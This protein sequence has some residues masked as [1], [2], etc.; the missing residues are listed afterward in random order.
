VRSNLDSSRP[1]FIG[2]GS[3]NPEGE[4]VLVEAIVY[5]E[6]REF[7]RAVQSPTFRCVPVDGLDEDT[8]W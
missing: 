5:S 3:G 4:R 8:L 1:R 7:V 2:V 6:A